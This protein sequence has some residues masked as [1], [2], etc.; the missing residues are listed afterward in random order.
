MSKKLGLA[1][2]GGGSRGVAHVG[3]LKALEEEGIKPDFIA[4][5]SMGAVVGAC[6]A[7]GMTADEMLEIAL[8]IKAA[9]L[10]DIS[11]LPITKLGLLRGNKMR[12][13]LLAHLGKVTFAELN[14]PFCC[15]AS[16]LYSGRVITMNEGLVATA[17]RASSS[18]P[19]IFP[20]VKH[21][22]KLLIDGGV[23]CRVPTEQV[24][25]MGAERV[26]AVDALVNTGES[27][28]EVKNMVTMIMRTFDIMDY[29]QSEMKKKITGQ[30]NELWLEPEMKGLNQYAIKDFDKAYDEGYRAAKEKMDEIKAF[31]KS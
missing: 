2:G 3:V 5:C 24:K 6:C 7:T 21:D 29:N 16:D 4:G 28:T 18:I 23:L 31:I 22:G 15:V 26:I 17:V 25:E 20:P 8:K 27:V 30:K 9:K 10:V 12:N 14:I 11:A 13:M 19:T 1:L